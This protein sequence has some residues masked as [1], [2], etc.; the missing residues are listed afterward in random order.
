M[1]EFFK[2]APDRFLKIFEIS[3]NFPHPWR[4]ESLLYRIRRKLAWR[5]MGFEPGCLRSPG[6][7][8][9][10]FDVLNLEIESFVQSPLKFGCLR[11]LDFALSSP[12]LGN[13]D[14]VPGHKAFRDPGSSASCFQ[15]ARWGRLA[16]KSEIIA[17]TV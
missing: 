16:S 3:H 17:T 12:H 6:Y 8:V 14:L 11:F 7:G 2:I 13:R 1:Q 5:S 10:V 9:L 15:R 4:F